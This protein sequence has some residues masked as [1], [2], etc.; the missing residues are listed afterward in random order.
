MQLT[1]T[2]SL[3]AV[4]YSAIALFALMVAG[5]GTV[6]FLARNTDE[7]ITGVVSPALLIAI[8]SAGVAIAAAVPGRRKY[9]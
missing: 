7:D 4:K 1:S 5:L 3:K 6:M 9:E 8:L 2:F